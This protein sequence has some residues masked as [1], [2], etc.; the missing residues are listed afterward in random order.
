MPASGTW[1]DFIAAF[2]A[3]NGETPTV[4]DR[5]Y[6]FDY[7]TRAATTGATRRIRT[8]RSSIA[9]R[10]ETAPASPPRT[11]RGARRAPRPLGVLCYLT[12]TEA[13]ASGLRFPA[14]SVART[15]KR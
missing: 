15:Q 5:S 9:D 1:D 10:S 4:T 3:P 6:E 14:P 12:L 11:G 13:Q 7:Y 8:R 2:F